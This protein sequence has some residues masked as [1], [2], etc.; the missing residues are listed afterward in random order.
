MDRAVSGNPKGTNEMCRRAKEYDTRNG[1]SP[2]NAY[3]ADAEMRVEAAEDNLKLVAR[4]RLR[5]AFEDHGIV[6]Q[7]DAHRERS[8]KQYD[9]VMD[10]YERDLWYCKE[11][12][13]NML[14]KVDGIS[15]K[16]ARGVDQY[17]T[18]SSMERAP[19]RDQW[20]KLAGLPEKAEQPGGHARRIQED[21][22][23]RTANFRREQE[24]LEAL[25]EQNARIE[26]FIEDK[27][28]DPRYSQRAYEKQAK[29]QREQV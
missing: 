16:I 19:F 25:R 22:R 2:Y 27:A 13:K 3:L 29:D 12:E 20:R 23:Q 9:A 4:R 18:A 26:L 15:R 1:G 14:K 8:K 6:K 21:V 24:A 7:L 28:G 11:E 5:D 17:R 10:L